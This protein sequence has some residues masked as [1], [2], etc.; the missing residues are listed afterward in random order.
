MSDTIIE[1]EKRLGLAPG[2]LRELI[3]D[4]IR[5]KNS[6]RSYWEH[7]GALWGVAEEQETDFPLVC[8]P[9]KE[10]AVPAFVM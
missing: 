1:L 2:E 9:R 10:P 3:A 7:R 4:S 8:G 5:E 6:G